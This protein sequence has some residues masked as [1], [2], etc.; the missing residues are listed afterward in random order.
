MLVQKLCNRRP[1]EIA[2]REE[3]GDLALAFIFT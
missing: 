2:I 1:F 3:Y